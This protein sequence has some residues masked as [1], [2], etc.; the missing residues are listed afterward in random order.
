NLHTVC[1]LGSTYHSLPLALMRAVE[2]GDAFIQSVGNER[3]S[4]A[5]PCEAWD[6]LGA[7]RQQEEL[8][9]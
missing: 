5:L 2:A 9:V 1:H 3:E 8:A 6:R 4:G 7:L